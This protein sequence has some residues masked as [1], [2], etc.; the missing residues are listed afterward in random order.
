MNKG[1]ESKLYLSTELCVCFKH[2]GYFVNLGIINYC[3][4]L[5]QMRLTLQQLWLHKQ[6]LIDM[7]TFNWMYFNL[8]INTYNA[9]ILTLI[10]LNCA[11]LWSAVPWRCVRSISRGCGC[12]S[13]WRSLWGWTLRWGCIWSWICRSGGRCSCPAEEAA[14]VTWL[15]A[16]T[17]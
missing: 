5:F 14:G 7:F 11:P 2:F 13:W 6:I 16:M 10:V 17:C 15:V 9:L 12:R 3:I 4:Y 1:K 8:F